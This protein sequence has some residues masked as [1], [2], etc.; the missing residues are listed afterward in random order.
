M[1]TLIQTAMASTPFG[2]AVRLVAAG[3]LIAAVVLFSGASGAAPGAQASSAGA[4]T[5]I[6]SWTGTNPGTEGYDF[7]QVLSRFTDTTG[8]AVRYTGTRALDQLLQS[9]IQQGSPP[10]LAI[11]PSPGELLQLERQGY[12]YPLGKVLNERK[13]AAAYGPQWLRIM[14]LGT[15][16]LYTLPVKTDLQN[17]VWYDPQ[18]WPAGSMPGRT[19]PTSWSQL[20]AL[21]Q[22]AA[23]GGSAA[24]C[25]GLDS[26]P[27][28][29]WPA[30]DWIGNILLAQSGTSVYESW[31]NGNLSWESPQVKQ[32]WQTWGRLVAGQGQ[33]YGGS[34]AA[35][36]SPWPGPGAA[37]DENPLFTPAPGCYLQ[38]AAS[39]IT[40]E[41]QQTPNAQRPGKG[42]D[43]FPFPSAGLPDEPPNAVNDAWEVSA[44]L[45]AMFR[46]TPAADL[47][48][49][50]RLVEFLAS[51][52][53]QRIWPQI[54]GGGASSADSQ[55][56]PSAYPD[57]VGQA[58]A[59]II[60]NPSS[61]LCFNASDAMPA[62]LQSAFYQ[63]VMEYLQDTSQLTGILKRLDQVR[64]ATYRAF[65]G[66]HPDFSCGPG[67]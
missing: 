52:Q 16:Q 35:L 33:L 60:T 24:W 5:V 8:I 38:N 47:P 55:V 28:S 6:A 1:K 18:D 45:L 30:T 54:P 53:A 29:G 26:P 48:D 10:D 65:P 58:V 66:G 40:L 50:E 23:A 39:F 17:L 51:E 36:I 11:L 3:A 7:Q 4:V 62:T 2:V 63:A 12:L 59:R 42:Y 20:V 61:V 25:L 46:S 41:Y 32:A 13:V 31:A 37:N 57:Q 14:E 19:A 67:S 9:D 44:D 56:P 49:T 34:T 15:G 43:F 27:S 64:L 22:R 21:E